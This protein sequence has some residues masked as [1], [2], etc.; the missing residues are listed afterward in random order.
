MD[1]NALFS[2][3][4]IIVLIVIVFVLINVLLLSKF[5]LSIFDVLSECFLI[6]LQFVVILNYCTIVLTIE[7][8]TLQY[9][10]KCVVYVLRCD[11]SKTVFVQHLHKM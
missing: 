2:S 9:C 4:L 11:R 6:G 3:A 5:N 1:L 8:I 7:A 10:L